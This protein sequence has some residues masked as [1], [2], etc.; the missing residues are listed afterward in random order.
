MSANLVFF[1]GVQ[2]S[3]GAPCPLWLQQDSGVAATLQIVEINPLPE[4]SA[5]HAEVSMTTLISEPDQ[6]KLSMLFCDHPTPAEA[7]KGR[8]TNIKNINVEI[9]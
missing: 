2:P 4:S 6:T 9:T 5:L 8:C 3:T 1:C 7:T